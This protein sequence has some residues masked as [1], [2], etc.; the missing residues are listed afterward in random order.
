MTHTDIC[1]WCGAYS[2][3]SCELEGEMGVCPW[4]ESEPDPDAAT[5]KK[6][7]AA[8]RRENYRQ[9]EIAAGRLKVMSADEFFRR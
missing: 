7:A 9:R 2:K 1:P 3:R 4:E 5:A 6:T 8:A